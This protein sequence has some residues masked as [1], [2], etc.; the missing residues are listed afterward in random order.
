[1]ET[2]GS[3][4]TINKRLARKVKREGKE[5]PKSPYAKRYVGIANGEVV[6]IAK[7]LGEMMKALRNVEPDASKCLGVDLVGDYDQ[8]YE[9]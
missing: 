1:M 6:V 2:N 3:I 9:V 4:R 7:S 5:N 8:V